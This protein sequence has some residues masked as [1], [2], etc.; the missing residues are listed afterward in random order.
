MKKERLDDVLVVIGGIIPD[1]DIPEAERAAASAKFFSP[2]HRRKTSLTY[3]R[4]FVRRNNVGGALASRLSGHR[5]APTQSCQTDSQS[6]REAMQELVAELRSKLETVKKGGGEA[7]VKRHKE[8]G[9]MF[10]RER[11]D[12]VL[13]P[14]H[15]FPGIQRARRKRHV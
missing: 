5:P 2:A 3:V 6:N 8:R 4:K 1:Q 10:V 15:A 13:D 14:G 12:A 11:I 9:K 7:A